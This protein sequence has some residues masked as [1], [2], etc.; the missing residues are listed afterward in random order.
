MDGIRMTGKKYWKLFFVSKQ[1][2]GTE[3]KT[4]EY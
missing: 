2:S 3:K 4:R 1:I